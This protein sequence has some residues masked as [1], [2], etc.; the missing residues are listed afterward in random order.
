PAFFSTATT[1]FGTLLT[2]FM[3][4]L[5]TFFCTV[6]TCF[7][8]KFTYLMHERRLL[9]FHT[10]AKLT[11]ICTIQT[12]LDTIPHHLQIFFFKTGIGTVGTCQG[13]VHT[14]LNTI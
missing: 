14:G 3:L 10:G 12:A 13:T 8:A 11:D 9:L 4:V 2:M 1:G 7:C 6:V 5:T